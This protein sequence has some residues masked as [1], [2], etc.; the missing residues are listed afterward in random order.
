MLLLYTETVVLTRPVVNHHNFAARLI[1]MQ[2]SQQTQ[3]HI[4]LTQ[5][6]KSLTMSLSGPTVHL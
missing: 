3:Q 4:Q 5:P 2:Q 6:Q 1:P